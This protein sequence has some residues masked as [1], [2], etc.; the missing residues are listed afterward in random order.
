MVRKKRATKKQLAAL[1]KGRATLAKKRK[2]A[3]KIKKHK[4]VPLR[5]CPK[6]ARKH[7]KSAHGSHGVGSFCR[8]HP[9]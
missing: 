6:C 5:Y 2:G 7:S 1:K 4:P 8:H 9:C 3:R